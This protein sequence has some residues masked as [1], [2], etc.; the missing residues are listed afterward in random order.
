M[1]LDVRMPMGLMF[2]VLGALLLVYGGL[3]LG[4]PGT[5]PTG[6]PINLIWGFFILVFG[7]ILIFLARR[8]R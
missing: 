3:T 2:S 7:L 1:G 4:R 6:V 8:A 5:A